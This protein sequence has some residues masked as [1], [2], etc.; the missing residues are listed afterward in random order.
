MQICKESSLNLNT[1]AC[2][3]TERIFEQGRSASDTVTYNKDC[4]IA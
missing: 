2:I 1:P 3:G 4:A